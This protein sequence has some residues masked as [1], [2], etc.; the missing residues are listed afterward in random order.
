MDSALDATGFFIFAASAFPCA[1]AGAD[2]TVKDETVKT[3]GR[4]KN[5]T[6]RMRLGSL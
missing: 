2:Q 3:I 6:R 4:D 1:I 5:D